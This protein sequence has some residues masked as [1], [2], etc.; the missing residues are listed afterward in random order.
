MESPR[1]LGSHSS[2]IGCDPPPRSL[3]LTPSL[4]ISLMQIIFQSKIQF[5]AKKT[6]P[7]P[8]YFT[9]HASLHLCSPLPFENLTVVCLLA[10]F[11]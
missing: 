7:K 1:K 2:V 3:P 4:T 8:A 10:F 11:S 9:S 6:P 5:R